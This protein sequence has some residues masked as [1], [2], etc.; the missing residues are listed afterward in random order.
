MTQ[1][2][3]FNRRRL[4]VATGLVGGAALSGLRLVARA[5]PLSIAG[6]FAGR[7]DDRGFMESG[8]RGLERARIELGVT[9]RHIDAVPPKQDQL[10]AALTTLAESGADLVI[11]HGGQN[12]EAALAVAAR[13]P[14]IASRWP[15]SPVARM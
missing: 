4:V 15:R 7:I 13:F 6:L 5:A 1:P 2:F 8:W 3:F 12:N 11:A 10:E 14:Q 9:A